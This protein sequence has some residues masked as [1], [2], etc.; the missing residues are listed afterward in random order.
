MRHMAVCFAVSKCEDHRCAARNSMLWLG[1]PLSQLTA[2]L[3][4]GE[5]EKGWLVPLFD[6]LTRRLL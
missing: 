3:D 4:D 2:A 6:V 1:V 5:H